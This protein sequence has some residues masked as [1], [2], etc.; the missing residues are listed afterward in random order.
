MCSGGRVNSI[1]RVD[2][3]NRLRILLWNAHQGRF[4]QS[5]LSNWYRFLLTQK[6]DWN[7]LKRKLFCRSSFKNRFRTFNSKKFFGNFTLWSWHFARMF[8]SSPNNMHCSCEYI[9]NGQSLARIGKCSWKR[10]ICFGNFTWKNP[11]NGWKLPKIAS[12]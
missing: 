8:T 6:V 7:C 5:C 9:P 4:H 12:N 3:I 2:W 10:A 11:R 1:W